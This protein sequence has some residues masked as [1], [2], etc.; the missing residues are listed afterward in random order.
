MKIVKN[1]LNKL[2]F[3]IDVFFSLVLIPASLIMLL[4]RKFGSHK[5]PISKKILNSFGIFPLTDQYYE[6]QLNVN[7]LGKN[8]YENRN[9]PGINLDLGGQLQNLS[10]LV[11]KNELI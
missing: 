10:N 8:L 3:P 7:G 11:Y 9:F 5:L 4:Y 6:L 1:I 2:K